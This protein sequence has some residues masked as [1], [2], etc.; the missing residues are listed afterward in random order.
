MSA[1]KLNKMQNYLE[2]IKGKDISQEEFRQNYSFKLYCFQGSYTHCLILV[3][4]ILLLER[5]IFVQLKT[6]NQNFSN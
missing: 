5:Y 1:R 4:L 3:T 6:R 2:F